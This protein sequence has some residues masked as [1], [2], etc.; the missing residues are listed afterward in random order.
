MA[1]PLH[2]THLHDI[3]EVILSN[4]LSSIDSPR[5]RNSYSLV[6]KK[7]LFIERSTRTSLTLRGN[8]RNMFMVPSCFRNVTELDLSLLSPWGH[9][10]LPDSSQD[11]VVL[12][13]F[14]HLAFPN[15]QSL[16]IYSRTPL[17]LQLLAPQWP[18]LRH[19]KL[20]RWHQRCS[21]P[22][23][24]D[25]FPLFE[26][27]KSLVSL[28]L[29]DFYCWTEDLPS[30]LEIHP[31]LAK[32]LTYLN[33]LT[34]PSADG[35]KSNEII[36]I[37]G[38]CPNL[39]ELLVTCMFDPR[40]IDFV[41]DEAL[42][43]L[44]EN[45]R[46]LFHLHLAD[47]SSLLN[48][49]VDVEDEGY[50]SEDAKISLGT[51]EEMFG[52]LPLLEELVLDICHNVRDSG[53]V[54]EVL[55]S[56]CPKLR[57]VKLGQFHG[58]CRPGDTKIEGIAMCKGL[59]SLWI[60][61]CADLNDNSLMG[62]ALGCPKLAKFHIQGCK[63]VTEIGMKNFA[64]VLRKSLIEVNISC[65]KYLDA[66]SAFRALEPVRHRIQRLHIDCEWHSLGG[67]VN[68]GEMHNGFDLNDFDE[69]ASMSSPYTE[70]DDLYFPTGTKR[71]MNGYHDTMKNKRCRY[72]TDLHSN[73]NGNGFTHK[74]WD[75]LQYLSLWIA[76]GDL[77]SPLHSMGLEI[78]PVLEEIHLKVEGDCRTKPK[79]SDQ[80]FGL[81]SLARYPQLLKMKIDCGDAIGY[82]L[83]A[84]SGQM[85]LS[86]WDRFYLNGIVN[87]NLNEI[88]YWPPQDRDVNN[89]G[90]SLPAAGLLAE[91]TTLRK[92][93]IHGTA[94][95]H[96][97]MML[98]TIPNLRE[99]Q[100][101][102]DYYPAPEDDMSTEM[103]VTSCTRF[104]NALNRRNIP[105]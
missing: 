93:F 39:G 83:T 29:S 68:H 104:E 32:L 60:K 99:M 34:L 98:L 52:K 94:H 70:S 72:S 26:N 42:M 90:L 67:P 6:C 19:V 36:T 45:C 58:V 100:L 66:A 31:D 80:A 61:N 71:N 77:L 59:E 88:D 22:V 49:R 73:G 12:A 81:I 74:T 11:S 23:G 4:I 3:P 97:L 78:C 87:L 63:N 76:V 41:G 15:V 16:T 82:A 79:P 38:A 105:D 57:S 75:R 95:E 102:E 14:L 13:Q 96:F 91:C 86:L 30:A 51:F 1:S 7:W 10:I 27:C 56:K 9:S 24:A 5:T 18:N 103:R 55:N 21:A 35:F 25:F 64:V 20:V 47:T 89:R 40:Y 65:C 69:E 92:L 84:P 28:D 53:V 50:T 43:A 44:A 8:V 37:T 2:Q 101:R 48:V 62:I 33:L 85:D 54:L 46:K 17:I